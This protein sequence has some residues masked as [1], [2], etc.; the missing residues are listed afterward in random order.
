MGR[1]SLVHNLEEKKYRPSREVLLDEVTGW[2]GDVT[3]WRATVMEDAW[4]PPL[5]S[6]KP[7]WILSSFVPFM[8]VLTSGRCGWSELPKPSPGVPLCSVSVF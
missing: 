4:L 3:E 2:R 1:G 5:S 6:S 7:S 8:K